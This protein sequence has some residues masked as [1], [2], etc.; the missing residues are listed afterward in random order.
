MV[1]H[2]A[3]CGDSFGVGCGLPDASCYEEN[4]SGV[5]ADYLKISQRVYARSGC[6]N[7]TIFLQVKKI[8]EQMT[9]DA[10][11]KPF[12]LITTTFHERLIFPLNDGFADQNPDLADVEYRSYIPYHSRTVPCRKIEFD[13]KDEPRLIT[14]TI[15]NI[16]HYQCGKADGIRELFVRVHRNKFD[17]IQKYFLELFD[18]GIKKEYDESLFVYMHMLLKQKDVPHVIMGN[19]LPTVIATENRM[20]N[21]WGE[22]TSKYPDNRG[23][24]HCDATGNRLVGEAVIAHIKQH[25]ML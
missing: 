19:H 25:N 6:C 23:S 14:E 10:D 22:Y 1:T 24:G 11:Y 18:T 16:E 8:L 9:R 2:L 20:Q 13:I 4:F 3:V 5:V 15:S 17:A 21:N 7:F 12:V